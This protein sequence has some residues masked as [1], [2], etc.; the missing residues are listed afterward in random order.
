MK[1][2]LFTGVCTA[3]VTPFLNNQ[4]NYPMLQQLLRRQMD[5]GIEAGFIKAY[6][7]MNKSDD[8]IVCILMDEFSLTKEEATNK[9]TNN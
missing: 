4:V 6:R 2:T 1:K 7:K 8:E 9:V 5:A 3:L